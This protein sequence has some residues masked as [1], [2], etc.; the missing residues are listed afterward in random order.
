M[1]RWARRGGRIALRYHGCV[2]VGL[3]VCGV[4]GLFLLVALLNLALMRRPSGASTAP[5]I[6]VL[7]PARNE[8]E[9]LA[10]LL[11][12]LGW[13]EK[14]LVFDDESSDDTAQVASGHGALVVRAGEPLPP[15]WTGKNRACHELAKVASE[16]TD[17]EWWV[18]LDA[19]ARPG[20][21]FPQ[22]IGSL[23]RKGHA[24]VVTGFPRLLA[25][26]GLEPVVLGWVPWILLS[27]NP[28]G[29][30][31]RARLGHN[32]F[33]NGQVVAWRADRYWELAPHQAVRGR[34]LED[35]AI[36]RLLARSGVRVEVGAL[37]SVLDVRMYDTP[38]QAWDGMSKNAFEIAGTAW[39]TWALALLLFALAWGWALAGTLWPVALGLLLASKLFSDRLV[40]YPVWTLPLMPV[41]LTVAAATL[42]RS[43]WWRCRGAA[44]WKGRRVG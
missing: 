31:S 2:G 37:A 7:I 5:R 28:F 6:A 15:D 20:P 30:V 12:L 34:V 40:R 35:V 21:G 24:P 4:Y 3:A 10:S 26:R 8:S 33:T 42:V 36:G 22:A 39:G 9:N 41:T 38:R 16:V 13:A 27:T 43:W 32:G 14:V 29:L 44:V 23:A 11:P 19:D 18:F 1:G 17:A 25:G